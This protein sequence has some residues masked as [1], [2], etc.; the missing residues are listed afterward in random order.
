MPN[1]SVKG[2]L[3]HLKNGHAIENLNSTFYFYCLIAAAK[4][5]LFNFNLEFLC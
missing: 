3:K 2:P 5:V 1:P 4:Q